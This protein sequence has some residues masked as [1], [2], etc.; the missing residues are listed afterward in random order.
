M[1]L[2]NINRGE[3]GQV[4]V[5]AVFALI[6]AM[7]FVSLAID[8]GMFYEERRITQNAVDAG[9]LAGAQ[10]LPDDGAT[11]EDIARKWALNNEKANQFESLDVSFRCVVGDRNQD[12]VPDA[13]D[14]PAVCNPGSSASFVCKGTLCA[15]M[16]EAKVSTNRCNTIV[17]SAAKDVPFHFGPVLSILDPSDK[18]IYEACSTGVISG[19]ACRGSCGAPPDQ[20]VDIVMILDRTNSMSATEL[21]N[22]KDGA[23]SALQVLNPQYQHVAL[24]VTGPATTSDRC[25]ASSSPTSG[26]WLPVNLNSNYQNANGSINTGSTLV[27]TIKCLPNSS[28][29]TNLGDPTRAARQYLTSNGRT[30]ARKVIVLFTDGA[31]NEPAATKPCA[32]AAGEATSAKNAGIE[33]Y[34]IGYGLEVEVCKETSGSYVGARATGLLADMATDSKDDHGGCTTQGGALAENA[35]G[36]HFLCQ[37]TSGDLG[38]VFKQVAVQIVS[39]GS[40]LIGLPE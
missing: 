25:A 26:S 33:V 3:G 4:V 10:E 13:G 20:P 8:I 18:C 9:A 35:D 40:S 17:V 22:A 28:V 12:G 23:L 5:L 2:S 16:C 38:T 30:N 39:S 31:A 37:P 24:G 21:Q 1:K 27:Q 15:S 34:T 6:V 14:V 19:V 29:G 7:G 32:Y 11:A 36:D